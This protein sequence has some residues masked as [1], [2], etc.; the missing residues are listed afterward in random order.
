M[1][2]TFNSI[3]G[4][5]VYTCNHKDS[6]RYG[7]ALEVEL[8]TA[9][10]LKN[11]KVSESGKIDV[12]YK[13]KR[14]EIKTNGGVFSY[15]GGKHIAK[16]MS[17]I[18]YSP[19]VNKHTIAIDNEGIETFTVDLFNTEF[20]SFDKKDFIELMNSD[21]TMLKPCNERNCI[22]IQTIYNYK[23]EKITNNKRYNKL[24]NWFYEYEL[25]NDLINDLFNK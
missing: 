14:Y 17:I 25:D 16:G 22:N 6:G 7:K 5:N 8:K 9:L 2:I 12:T 20:Y 24:L 1:S 23:T 18:I 19:Y 11:I 10:N 4:K 21:S 15:D 13:K 3:N